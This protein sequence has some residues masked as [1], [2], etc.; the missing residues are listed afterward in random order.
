MGSEN[1][2]A[3]TEIFSASP[4]TVVVYCSPVEGAPLVFTTSAVTPASV[5]VMPSVVANS[6]AVPPKHAVMVSFGINTSREP[7]FNVVPFSLK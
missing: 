3:D 6:V 2:T 4:I 5:R 7:V 1:D